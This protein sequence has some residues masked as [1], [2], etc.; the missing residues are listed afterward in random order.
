MTLEAYREDFRYSQRHP[1]VRT[2]LLVCAVAA[3]VM[4]LV[5]A[6]YWW[7]AWNATATLRLR[8]SKNAGKPR[9]PATVHNL[10]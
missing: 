6:A 5:G 7:P 3:L 2:G 9:R 10:R 8:S 1:R 4:L